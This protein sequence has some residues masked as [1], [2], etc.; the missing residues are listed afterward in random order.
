[1]V[2]SGPGNGRDEQIEVLWAEG[3]TEGGSSGSG[4]LY[5]GT[6]RIAGMLSSGTE[7]TCGP[8]RSNNLDWFASVR[9]FHSQIAPYLDTATPSTAEG[10]DDCQVASPI[11]PFLFTY[12]SQPAVLASFRALRDNVLLKSDTGERLVAAYYKVAPAMGDAVARSPQAR[13]LF[14]AATGPLASLL[15]DE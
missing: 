5:A 9:G 8:D 2:V 1:M 12:S 7:H 10:D 13:G 3:V 11:C 15:T 14:A 6:N 4:L